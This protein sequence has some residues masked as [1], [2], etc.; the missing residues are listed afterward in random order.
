M[1]SCPFSIGI[2]SWKGY[3]SLL[4]SLI[5]YEKNGLSK[6]TNYKYICLPE[7]ENEGIEIAKK[8]SYEPILFKEN[9][10]ILRGFKELAKKMPSGPILLLENDLPLIEN[11]KETYNQ[12]QKS[13]KFLAKEKVIQV[14]LRSRIIPGEPFIGVKKYNDFWSNDLQSIIKRKIRPFK[15]KRLI[16]TSV[17]ALD[18]ADK[19]HPKYINN[20]ADGFYSVSSAVLTWANL[21]VLVDRDNFLNIIISKAESVNSTNTINGFK[22][23]EIELNNSWWRKKKYEIIIAPGLFTHHRISDRGY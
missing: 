23:I 6:L 14:R 17:Y 22:N 5:S 19:R 13:I 1:I 3:D 2:L 9:L 12:I 18:N 7:Y 8:F 4:N 16:G 21:A 11:K 10:G 15:S 20:L